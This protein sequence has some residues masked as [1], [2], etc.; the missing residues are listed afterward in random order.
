MTIQ[1]PVSQAFEIARFLKLDRPVFLTPFFALRGANPLESLERRPS[2]VRKNNPDRKFSSLPAER[3]CRSTPGAASPGSTA[4]SGARRNRRVE[5]DGVRPSSPGG[6]KG[7][8]QAGA[9]DDGQLRP[10]LNR[11]PRPSFRTDAAAPSRHFDRSPG[12]GRGAPSPVIST[13]A[14]APGRGGVEKSGGRSV[15]ATGS[16]IWPASVASR[17]SPLASLRSK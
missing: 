16:G 13:G 8:A 7:G 1:Y 2:G 3:E 12:P 6:A 14:P 9:Q 17:I 4:D 15:G 5:P 10:F 11:R